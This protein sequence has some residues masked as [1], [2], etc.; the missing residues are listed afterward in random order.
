IYPN[1]A[2]N[3]VTVSFESDKTAQIELLNT[4]MQNVSTYN[5]LPNQGN[6]EKEIETSTLGSGMYFIRI[7]VNG[8]SGMYK[9]IIAR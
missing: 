5:I 4:M 1:P 7:Q 2:N 6:I 3:S 8:Q 9:L